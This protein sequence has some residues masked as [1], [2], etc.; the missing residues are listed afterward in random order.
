MIRLPPNRD[1]IAT[2]VIQSLISIAPNMIFKFETNKSETNPTRKPTG[3][4][5][6]GMSLLAQAAY[7][8]ADVMISTAELTA[9]EKAKYNNSKK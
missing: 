2:S 6:E 7:S 1:I 9:Q 8:M 4:N 5:L 3:I